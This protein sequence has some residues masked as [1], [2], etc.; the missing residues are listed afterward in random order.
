MAP[1]AQKIRTPRFFKRAE[2]SGSPWR[3]ILWGEIRRIPFNLMVGAAGVFTSE[4]LFG[5]EMLSKND[6]LDRILPDPPALAT[7]GH[8]VLANVCLTVGRIGE[9]LANVIFKEQSRQFG[10]ISLLFG[11][12]FS[13]LIYS[14]MAVKPR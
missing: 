3:I 13:I 9:L 12:A 4:F 5:S 6:F 2:L 7:F 14:G 8:G 1:I 10:E 11:V